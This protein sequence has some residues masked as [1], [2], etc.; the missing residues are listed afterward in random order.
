PNLT[1]LPKNQSEG[2]IP[3]MAFATGMVDALECVFR[4]IGVD[5]SE[6]SVPTSKGGKGRI[7]LWM[8]TAQGPGA[9]ITPGAPP[10][11]QLWASPKELNRY[12][13]VFLPCEG[14]PYDE[15]QGAQQNLIAYAN[16]GGRVFATHYSYVW[17][18]QNTWNQSGDFTNVDQS[19]PG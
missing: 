16:A 7:Q 9:D 8:T 5:D 13:I 12:D 3:L 1:R 18:Y 6:F 10:E 2:D 15:M 11:D 4:K 19:H 17:L 14:K